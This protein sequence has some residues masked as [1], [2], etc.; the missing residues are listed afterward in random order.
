MY[1]LGSY[2]TPALGQ[3]NDDRHNYP[4]GIA[5][6]I[7][8]KKSTRLPEIKYGIREPATLDLGDRWRVL[9]GIELDTLPGEYVVYVKP[10]GED[11]SAYT[12]KF[13]VV[14]RVYPIKDHRNLPAA[15]LEYDQFSELDYENSNQPELPLVFPVNLVDQW[16]DDFGH[17]IEETPE[18]LVAQNYISLTTTALTTV[19]AP[20]NAIVSRIVADED[21]Y[22]TVFLDH[23]R[24][25]YSI[26]SGVDDLVVEVGNGVVAGAVIGKLPGNSSFDRP[27]TVTWQCT[28]NGVYINPLIL[29]IL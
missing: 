1:L 4:G 22:A 24:G 20:Q 12:E 28:L 13:S 29:T 27:H 17:L 7:L 10:A 2:L 5:D 8:E 3:T 15:R 9:I 16:S 19:L 14:Q 25:L 26:I 6:L 23:G 11:S 21:D 18:S